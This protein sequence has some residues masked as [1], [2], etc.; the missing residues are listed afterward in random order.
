MGSTLRHSR[1]WNLIESSR[2][3]WDAVVGISTNAAT[4]PPNSIL[5]CCQCIGATIG[6]EGEFSHFL[7]AEMRHI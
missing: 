2:K 1:E 6:V 7:A 5:A 3:T 4:R